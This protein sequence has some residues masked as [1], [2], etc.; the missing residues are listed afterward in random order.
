M[1]NAFPILALDQA[2]STGWA[3]WVNSKPVRWGEAKGT[4]QCAD[5]IDL[6]TELTR[7]ADNDPDLLRCLVVFEDHSGMRMGGRRVGGVR[8]FDTSSATLLGLGRAHGWW[9]V[10]LNQAG[11]DDRARIK[12]PPQTWKARVL[13][14]PG[15]ANRETSIAAAKR[16]AEALGVCKSGPDEAVAMV[17][18]H[19]ASRAPEA[20]TAWDR[21]Y[22]PK[23]RKRKVPA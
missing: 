9:E 22:G 12:I 5:V 13:G 2:G 16:H 6:A 20:L 11:H 21:A 10:L 15:S 8:T 1:T 17:M 18:A 7:S 4:S 14:L 19:W 23:A 3:I